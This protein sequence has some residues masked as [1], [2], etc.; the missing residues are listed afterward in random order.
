MR[1][2]WRSRVITGTAIEV[3]ARWSRRSRA[4]GD[5]ALEPVLGLAGDLDPLLAGLLAEPRDPAGLRGALGGIAVAGASSGAAERADDDDLV[6]VDGDLGAG[7]PVVGQ[8]TGEPAV[9]SSAI[10]ALLR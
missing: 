9:M 8:P 7:E 2:G 10:T 5:L 6:P 3:K 1:S 4:P